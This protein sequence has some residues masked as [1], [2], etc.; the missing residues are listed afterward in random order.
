[1]ICSKCGNKLADNAK[2]CGKCGAPVEAVPERQ[3]A[4][5]TLPV[6]EQQDA[7]SAAETT[8][9]QEP[10]PSMP[11]E[12]QAFRFTAQ[13]LSGETVCGTLGSA[14]AGAAAGMPGPGKVIGSGIKRLISSLGSVFKEPKKLIPAAA[15]AIL[16]LVLDILKASGVQGKFL[17]AL[18]FLS[19]A[20]GGMSGGFFGAIGGLIGKGLFAGALYCLIGVFSRKSTGSRRS[21]KDSLTGVFGVSLDTLWAY[22]TG[23]GAAM[24]LYLFISGGATRLSFMGGIAAS[25]LAARA[26]LSGGFLQQFLGS[27]AAKGKNIARPN[28]QGII[29]GLSAGFAAAA[30]IGLTGVNLILIIT[31]AVLLVGGA[32]MMILQAKGVV[33]LGKGAQAQ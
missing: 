25:F 16:W 33:T 32:V 27:F 31:G 28:V 21:L 26:A 15:L 12:P 17:Q 8:T 10:E 2:F 20:N 13:K 4:N 1:M 5:Q 24:L 23:V 9:M 3:A 7:D 18:S 29:R 19:F 30:L 6:R 11:E 22:L 14:A